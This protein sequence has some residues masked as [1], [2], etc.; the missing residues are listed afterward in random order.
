MSLF[1]RA[2]MERLTISL[3]R[4]Q[5][6]QVASIARDHDASE[7][8]VIRA[9]LELGL[10]KLRRRLLADRSGGTSTALAGEEE[11]EGSQ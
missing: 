7:A 3:P 8:A 10:P 4:E 11:P 9:A 5:R 6:A 2:A 1:D